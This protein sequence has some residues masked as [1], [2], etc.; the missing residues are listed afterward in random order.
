MRL[1][2]SYII[3]GDKLR[4]Y[5][6]TQQ[7]PRLIFNSV[8]RDNN[9]NAVRYYLAI[10]ILL[11]HFCVLSGADVIQLPRIFGGAGSFFAI[12]G[13][14]MFPSFEKRPGLKR[15]FSRR[16]KRI[17]PPYVFIVLLAAFGLVFVS[18]LPAGEYFCS[19]EFWSYLAANLSFL[20]FLSPDL[21]GV[22]TDATNSI[23]AVNGSLWTMK[24]EVACYMTVP[25]VFYVVKVS[26]VRMARMLELLMVLFGA[27]YIMLGYMEL[28]GNPQ[29]DVISRQCRVMFLFYMGGYL[30][31]HLSFIR[32]HL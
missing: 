8:S 32:R 12:S 22:F 17:F 31:V 16:A 24:G 21:P 27:A 15:Y 4:Y 18:N 23:S 26:G 19:K 14:L 6:M 10:C 2:V 7:E 13:F 5:S 3:G 25:L 20:N 29:L 11:N 1:P 30:N 9:I 28:N